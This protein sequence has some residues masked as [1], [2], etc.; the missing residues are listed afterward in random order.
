MFSLVYSEK[1]KFIVITHWLTDKDL[2]SQ[3][4]VTL[5]QKCHSRKYV[6]ILFDTIPI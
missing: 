2:L 3:A 1:F 4:T 5:G 6:S